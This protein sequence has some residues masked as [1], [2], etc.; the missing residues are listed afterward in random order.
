M[1]DNY[2][3]V[4][5]YSFLQFLLYCSS[6]EQGAHHEIFFQLS[7]FGSGNLGKKKMTYSI[8]VVYTSLVFW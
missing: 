8:Q 1:F 3:S 6:G 2:Y 5:V 4:F 7:G